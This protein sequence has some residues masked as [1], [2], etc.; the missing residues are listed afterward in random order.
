MPI[1]RTAPDH[2][3]YFEM[4]GRDEADPRSMRAAIFTAVDIWRRRRDWEELQDG[5][6]EERPQEED[7]RERPGKPQIA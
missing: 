7:R 2:G 6:L 5:R 4:A 1:I 3:T